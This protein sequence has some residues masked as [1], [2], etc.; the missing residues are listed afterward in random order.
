MADDSR[1]NQQLALAEQPK[2]SRRP[3]DKHRGPA[4]RASRPAEQQSVGVGIGVNVGVGVGVGVGSR[5]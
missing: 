3:A 4:S 2:P 5:Q 1:E